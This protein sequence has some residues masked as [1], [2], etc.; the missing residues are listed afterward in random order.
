MPRSNLLV[1]N[2]RVVYAT[3][4]HDA[5]SAGFSDNLIYNEIPLDPSQRKVI[6]QHIDDPV[7][8]EVFR[9]WEKYEDKIRY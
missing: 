9:L 1:G 2:R 4:R 5:A 3:D 7:A 8:N 6:F